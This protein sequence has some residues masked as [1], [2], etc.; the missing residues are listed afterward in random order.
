[1]SDFKFLVTEKLQIYND[2]FF[3]NQNL[4]YFECIVWDEVN[5]SNGY[6]QFK[7]NQDTI[8]LILHNA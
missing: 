5:E 3:Y 1:M 8:K 6:S 4:L 7:V 2:I